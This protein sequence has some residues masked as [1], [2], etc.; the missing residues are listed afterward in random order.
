MRGVSL[1]LSLS[2]EDIPQVHASELYKSQTKLGYLTAQTTDRLNVM[3]LS[4]LMRRSGMARCACMPGVMPEPPD[5]Y[6]RACDAQ[7]RAQDAH[8]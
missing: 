3:G 4:R 1:S 6:R 8:L 5:A 2:R 7:Q